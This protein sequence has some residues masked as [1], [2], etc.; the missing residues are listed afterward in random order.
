VTQKA[1]ALLMDESSM[2]FFEQQL[3]IRPDLAAEACEYVK[4]IVLI[5]K[6]N[7]TV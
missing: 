4:S 7:T 5:Y 1:N 3:N 6:D 2:G